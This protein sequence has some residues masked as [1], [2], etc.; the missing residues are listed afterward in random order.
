[1]EIKSGTGIDEPLI[2]Q[3]NSIGFGGDSLFDNGF[4][5]RV[6]FGGVIKLQRG[7]FL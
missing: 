2:L 6:V 7:M 3:R 1:M 5:E 4:E